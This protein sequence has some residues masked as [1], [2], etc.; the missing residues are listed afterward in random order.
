MADLTLQT[1]LQTLFR[2]HTVGTRWIRNLRR[3]PPPHTSR[4]RT[5]LAGDSPVCPEAEGPRTADVCRTRFMILRTE[6]SR[7]FIMTVVYTVAQQNHHMQVQFTYIMYCT[8]YCVQCIECRVSN[9]IIRCCIIL[10]NIVQCC[11]LL[12]NVKFFKKLRIPELIFC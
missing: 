12:H 4:R 6:L 7:I 9:N 10:Y 3:L 8:V 1:L 5:D 11:S 2:G